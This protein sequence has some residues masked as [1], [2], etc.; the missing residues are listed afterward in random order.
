MEQ[1]ELREQR[2][3][4]EQGEHREHVEQEQKESL[5]IYSQTRPFLWSDSHGRTGFRE[6]H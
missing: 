2:G 1:R 5:G 3:H 6:P 4:R